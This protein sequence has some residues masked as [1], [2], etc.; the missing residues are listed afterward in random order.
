MSCG[1]SCSVQSCRPQVSTYSFS[2]NPNST[3]NP[4]DRCLPTLISADTNLLSHQGR[5]TKSIHHWSLHFDD[6]FIWQHCE[7]AWCAAESNRHQSTSLLLLSKMQN[8]KAP[9]RLFR[10]F[11]LPETFFLF[12]PWRKV[13]IPSYFCQRT[14]V[15]MFSQVTAQGS[16]VS[17]LYKLCAELMYRPMCAAIA[18]RKPGWLL[19]GWFQTAVSSTKV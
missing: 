5:E 10:A 1:I 8:L 18:C 12:L 13:D 7:R 2:C 15:W 11:I 6:L 19:S 16:Q 4:K 14:S 9:S 17:V 3:H